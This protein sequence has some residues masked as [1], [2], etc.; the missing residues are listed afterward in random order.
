[1]KWICDLAY[2][3]LLG[4]LREWVAEERD[5]N[6]GVTKIC[7]YMLTLH[8]TIFDNIYSTIWNRLHALAIVVCILIYNFLDEPTR[9]IVSSI[10]SH[11]IVRRYR[12][13][14]T[15]F[16]PA[17][18]V[19]WGSWWRNSWQCD[20]IDIHIVK[21]H[22]RAFLHDLLLNFHLAQ[23]RREAYTSIRT[24]SMYQAI[25]ILSPMHRVFFLHMKLINSYRFQFTSNRSL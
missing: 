23:F 8:M 11:A 3:L 19:R 25:I 21:W 4:K 9:R 18:D 16:V 2:T 14:H 5:N 22:V 15:V 12:I 6:T 17:L 24:F 20:W 1:M 13:S 7:I 10:H